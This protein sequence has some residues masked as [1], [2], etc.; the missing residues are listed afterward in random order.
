MLRPGSSW[1]ALIVLLLGKPALGQVVTVDGHEPP[2][3]VWD[4]VAPETVVRIDGVPA[5]LT[6]H[7]V[8][9]HGDTVLVEDEVEPREE[10]GNVRLVF[11]ALQLATVRCGAEPLVGLVRTATQVAG[12]VRTSA[13]I[14]C[15]GAGEIHGLEAL[16]IVF[17]LQ[18]GH[19]FTT[20]RWLPVTALLVLKLDQAP[21]IPADLL[22]AYVALTTD[23]APPDYPQPVS[24]AELRRL[25]NEVLGR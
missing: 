13:N 3:S 5:G 16:P 1:L 17:G 14:N 10:P 7:A 18:G 9:L 21:E 19:A 25:Q 11:S 22:V 12:T 2:S 15:L 24:A 4:Y 23:G 20:G 6:V 8:L